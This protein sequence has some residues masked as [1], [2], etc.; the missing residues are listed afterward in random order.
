MK[1]RTFIGAS[2][3]A[4]AATA[5]CAWPQDQR[6]HSGAALA[7]G[8][9]ISLQVVHE[10]PDVAA[11]AIEDA[12]HAVQGVDRLMSVYRPGSQVWQL[13]RTGRL[14]RPDPQ[15]LAVLAQARQL[16]EWT[17]GAFDISVQPL[18]QI[19]SEAAARGALPTDEDRLRALALVD[20]RG[21]EFDAQQVS[22]RRPGMAITL[23][24]LAQGYA[25]DLAL[26]AVQAHGVRHALLDTGEFV[27]RGQ[28]LHHRP[29]VLGVRD[30][31]DAEALAA[32]IQIDGCG[33]AT[34]GDYATTF[35]ADFRHHHIFD[36][37]VGDSPSELSSVTVMAP[38]A[39][40]ADGLSTACMVLGGERA[41]V[42]AAQ[43]P[44]VDLLLIDKQGREWR[45][46]TFPAQA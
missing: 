26:A 8:T 5:M 44:A 35:T 42:L 16:S 39:M 14:Q 21:V 45:S 43:L 41:K 36:P 9:T 28:K 11:R 30:P 29:W 40:L 46:A 34:S 1:R 6:H 17:G 18:W 33:M 13:N 27:A 10:D 37:A 4:I 20:W 24:G 15:L 32:T 25:A 23:N 12:L 2:L 7:F 22:L 19:F 31:R 3:G 38:T